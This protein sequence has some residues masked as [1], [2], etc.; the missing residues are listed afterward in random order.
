MPPRSVVTLSG[1]SANP[2][3][4]RGQRSLLVISQRLSTVARCDRVVVLRGG[5][6]VS[7]G[8]FEQLSRES[9]DFRKWAGLDDEEPET[10][11][12]E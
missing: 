6:V 4:L 8:S 10:E 9:A 3:S 5:Q 11:K 1:R 2:E 12:P 7:E